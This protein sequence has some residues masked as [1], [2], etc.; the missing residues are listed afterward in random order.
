MNNLGRAHDGFIELDQLGG[1]GA[2][3]VNLTL[4][5]K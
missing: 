1:W 5:P 3:A 2:K 4:P